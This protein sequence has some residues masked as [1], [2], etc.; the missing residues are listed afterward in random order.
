MIGRDLDHIYMPYNITLDYYT[1][2]IM[3]IRP[4]EQKVPGTLRALV[5]TYTLKD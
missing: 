4:G 1:D 2:D 5:S 3:L